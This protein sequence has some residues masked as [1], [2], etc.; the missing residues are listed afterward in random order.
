MSRK[1]KVEKKRKEGLNIVSIVGQVSEISSEHLENLLVCKFVLVVH[2]SYMNKKREIQIDTQ[3]IKVECYNKMAGFADEH[4]KNGNFVNVHGS[5]VIKDGAYI[6][7]SRRI[8]FVP[9]P[10]DLSDTSWEYDLQE[11][12]RWGTD[13]QIDDICFFIKN[14]LNRINKE[15]TI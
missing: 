4:I 2:R 12:V 3:N 8:S 9:E 10:V 15:E 7:Q 14:N 11:E 5:M 6:V 1:K 13:D